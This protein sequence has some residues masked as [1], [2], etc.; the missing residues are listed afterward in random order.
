MK[1][2]LWDGIGAASPF[3]DL[4]AAVRPR[5]PRTGNRSGYRPHPFLRKGIGLLRTTNIPLH[6]ST[7]ESRPAIDGPERCAPCSTSTRSQ[8]LAI[9]SQHGSPYKYY[10]IKDG[11]SLSNR[12]NVCKPG[13]DQKTTESVEET[14]QEFLC[15][16]EDDENLDGYRTEY[17][18]L[19]QAVKKSQ[20][21]ENRLLTK[22]RDLKAKILSNS[23]K[24]DT[25]LKLTEDDE[26]LVSVLQKEVNGAWQRAN[27]ASDKVLASRETIEALQHDISNLKDL[28]MHETFG[29]KIK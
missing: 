22:C 29:Q 24:V 10:K 11:C 28:L 1:V 18:K 17:E 2:K 26:S 15:Q 8:L 21:S 16:L 9:I 13:A 23:V 5:H 25:A 6:F 3:V 20:E 14:F 12:D 19:I 27:Q 4:A 7:T